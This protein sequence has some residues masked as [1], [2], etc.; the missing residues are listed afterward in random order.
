MCLRNTKGSRT[1]NTF[2]CPVPQ[3]RINV[4]SYMG[5]YNHKN[6]SISQVGYT[7]AYWKNSYWFLT[8]LLVQRIKRNRSLPK[9]PKSNWVNNI[10]FQI[11]NKRPWRVDVCLTTGNV[12]EKRETSNQ[13]SFDLSPDLLKMIQALSMPSATTSLLRGFNNTNT[14]DAFKK[15]PDF[16]SEGL[17][18]FSPF[19]PLQYFYEVS[20]PILTKILSVHIKDTF[21]NTIILLYSWLVF[22]GIGTFK[23][24]T[25]VW[26]I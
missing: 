13:S 10:N 7:C 16:S 20:L 6:L 3:C 25:N 18:F 26:L 8:R 22:Q 11:R 17:Q 9:Y 21:L 15:N 5:L 23:V 2:F 12:C 24:E 14:R 19:I 1:G 4:V